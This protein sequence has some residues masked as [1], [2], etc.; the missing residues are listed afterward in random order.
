M[1]SCLLLNI[2]RVASELLDGGFTPLL[3]QLVYALMHWLG[4]SNVA[5]FAE[6]VVNSVAISCKYRYIILNL[7]H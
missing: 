7:I 4:D 3:Q 5:T 1:V 6:G 2:L